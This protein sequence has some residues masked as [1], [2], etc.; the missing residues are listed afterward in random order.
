M[1]TLLTITTALIAL[2]FV[3]CSGG[4]NAIGGS[5]LLEAD[6]VIVSAEMPGRTER[7]YFDEGSNVRSGDTLLSIDPSRLKLELAATEAA[8]DVSQARLNT[9]RIQAEQ[10]SRME[11]F[12]KSERDRVANLIKSGSATQKQLDQLEFE[13]AQAKLAQRAA[14][15]NVATVEAELKKWDADIRKAQRL[16][17]DCYPV[18][19]S[20]GTIIE[21][22][23]EAGEFLSPGKPIA[24][25]ARLDTMWVKVYLPSGSFAKVS[26]GDKATVDTESGET[27]YPGQVIWTSQEAEFTPKNVQTEKSRANLVY[28][29]KVRIPNTDGR[30]KIGM[31]VY[32]ALA[33]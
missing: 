23:V 6:E 24:K 3:G 9:T 4:D 31:P 17:S 20:T 8:S 7:L 32:V 33:R 29:V 14:A 12:A 2:G 18:A 16:L 1:R 5:G 26:V 11:Q 22:L 21:K 25:I 13:Y 10:A 30:L 28:A 15:A 19:P 27:R